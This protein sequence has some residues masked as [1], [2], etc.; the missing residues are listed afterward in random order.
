VGRRKLS[1]QIEEHSMQE[2]EE[3]KPFAG[4]EEVMISTGSTLLD[5]Y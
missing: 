1:E 4:N 5:S 2:L 3:L